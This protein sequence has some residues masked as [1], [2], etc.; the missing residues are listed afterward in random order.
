VLRAPVE[1]VYI[2]EREGLLQVWNDRGTPAFSVVPAGYRYYESLRAQGTQADTIVR[3]MFALLEFEE[4][5]RRFPRT[6]G[7]WQQAAVLLWSSDSRE[8]LTTIGHSC[9]EAMHMQEFTDEFLTPF[10]VPPPHPE[11]AQTVARL[12]L[13]I[14]S[15]A[16]S[17]GGAERSV[18]D[19]VTVLW[20]SVSDLAQRQEH[21][22]IHEA[23]KLVWEDGRR[24]VFQTLNVLTELDRSLGRRVSP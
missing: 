4:F 22:A 1:D 19:A 20:G 16:A 9:R 18:P 8:Q 21:G 2:L 7:K 14:Q 11:K 5:K 13:I 3:E 15:N 6:S 12:K 24:L 10:R 17:M 23:E